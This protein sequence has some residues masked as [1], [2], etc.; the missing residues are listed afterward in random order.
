MKYT[1]PLEKRPIIG[2]LDAPDGNIRSKIILS[3]IKTRLTIIDTG[4][5]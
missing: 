2:P 4:F 3:C 5:T 1:G